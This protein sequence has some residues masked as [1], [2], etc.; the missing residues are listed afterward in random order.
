MGKEKH[1]VSRNLLA[2]PIRDIN[3][4]VMLS[5]LIQIVMKAIEFKEMY[6]KNVSLII[7]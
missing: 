2:M 1:L 5:I 4:N 3:T 6:S 7:K